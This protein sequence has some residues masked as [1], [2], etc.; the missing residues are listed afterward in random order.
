M[1]NKNTYT[2]HLVTIVFALMTMSVF[3][4]RANESGQ[5]TDIAGAAIWGFIA[6]VSILLMLAQISRPTR[7]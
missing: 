2:T 5:W 3:L 6:L 1:G 4:S 7:R